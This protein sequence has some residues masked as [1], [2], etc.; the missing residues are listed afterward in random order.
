MEQSCCNKGDLRKPEFTSFS[1]ETGEW[2]IEGYGVD[3][4]IEIDN[5]PYKEY[6]GIDEQLNKAIEVVKEELKSWKGLPPVP[7]ALD[8]SK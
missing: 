6:I 8:K 3:P 4:D 7:A 1:T 5:D 2:I